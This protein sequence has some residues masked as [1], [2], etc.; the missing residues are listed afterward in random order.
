MRAH[1]LGCPVVPLLGVLMYASGARS[2]G[3]RLCILLGSLPAAAGSDRLSVQ[4]QCVDG[5]YDVEG[6][7]GL[8]PGVSARVVW[9]VLSDYD[10]LG[11]FIKSLE[12]SQ[13][14]QRV[15]N[16]VLLEQQGAGKGL[17]AMEPFRVLLH[18]HEEPGREIDFRDVLHQDFYLYEGSWSL[19]EQAGGWKV[20]YRLRAKPRR[21]LPGF[22]GKPAFEASATD[23]LAELR[24]EIVRR[25]KSTD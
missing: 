10:H 5:V 4:E 15:G 21:S 9:D 23:L 12:Q 22:I 3:P 6:S 24:A 20:L 1:L 14:K 19:C 13:V 18:V 2:A 17:L 7:F 11:R 25:S 8:Q 16:E